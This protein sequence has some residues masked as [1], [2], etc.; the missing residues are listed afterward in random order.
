MA[1]RALELL[2]HSQA[3]GSPAPAATSPQSPR[4]EQPDALSPGRRQAAP[5]GSSTSLLSGTRPPRR[6]DEG[7]LREGVSRPPSTRGNHDAACT[8]CLQTRESPL[9]RAGEDDERGPGG[10]CGCHRPLRQQ[11]PRLSPLPR[12][13]QGWWLP[14]RGETL[15]ELVVCLQGQGAQHIQ[16]AANVPR[17]K[18]NQNVREDEASDSGPRM[19]RTEHLCPGLRRRR[20]WGPK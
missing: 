11:Q 16:E 6:E 7:V 12:E 2:G 13:T 14:A 17:N 9:R 3:A 15:P 20:N 8:R 4:G 10:E 19:C 5:P 18:W 1:R